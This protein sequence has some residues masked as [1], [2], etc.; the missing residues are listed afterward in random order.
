MV[1]WGG[2]GD[3]RGQERKRSRATGKVARTFQ[4]G[5]KV[6]ASGG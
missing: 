6:A 2:K 3:G 5:K 4:A 1:I